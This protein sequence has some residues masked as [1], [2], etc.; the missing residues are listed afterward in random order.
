M[1]GNEFL[2]KMELIDPAYVEAADATP[3]KKKSVWVKWG[4]MAACL[5]IVIAG[6]IIWQHPTAPNSE[7][8]GVILPENGITIPKMDISL[9]ADVEADMMAF[10]IYQGNCYVQYEW[11]YD[12]VDIVGE[13]LGT[14]TGLIDEWTSKEGYV[15]LAGSVKGDFFAVKGYDPSFMLCMKDPTGAVSTYIC[16]NGITLK[17]GSELYEDKLHLSENYNIVQYETRASWNY[18]KDDLYQLDGSHDAINNFIGLLD[19][20]EFIPWGTIPSKEG[21]T[22]TTIYDTEIYHMYFKM[23]NG[24]TIH[25]RLYENG[26]V[27][28]QGLLDVC[29][30][31]PEDSFKSLIDLLDSHIDAVPVTKESQLD[32]TLEKCK[33]D[34]ELGAYVPSFELSESMP[35]LAEMYY[36]IDSQTGAETGAKEIYVEYSSASNPDLYYSVTI[37]WRNEYGNNGWAGPMLDVSELTVDAIAEHIKTKSSNGE[38]KIDL[39]VWYDDVSVV[40]S[41]HGI[42]AETAFE[43]FSSVK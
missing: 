27:R 24:T 34:P 16:N 23:N 15:E 41:S 40:L 1:R 11:I 14:A 35:V 26:Y 31:V 39:G 36:Y 33:S 43:I 2:D 30:Q 19:T 20:A 10:F 38:T 28:F 29:I 32:M 17:Y 8:P 4:A 6:T 42:D 37:T 7:D 22:Q 13:R 12:D 3:K 5:C 25:L 21:K 18:S 9:S